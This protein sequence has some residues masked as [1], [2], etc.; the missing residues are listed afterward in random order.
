[1]FQKENTWKKWKGRFRNLVSGLNGCALSLFRDERGR[2]LPA[3]LITLAVGSLLLTPF[4]SFVSTRSLGIR[5]AK[6]T[7]NEQYASDAGIEFGIWA[8]LND[9]TFRAQADA[10]PGTAYAVPFPE[11][12]NGYTPSVDITAIPIGS[13]AWTPPSFPPVSIGQGGDMVFTGGNFIYVLQG[14]NSNGFWRYNIASNAWTSLQNTQEKVQSNGG[15]VY[16]GGDY[17]YAFFDNKSQGKGNQTDFW[18][19]SISN[20]NWRKMAPTPMKIGNDTALASPGGNLIYVFPGKQQKF[21]AYNI[22]GDSW[23]NLSPTPG[24]IGAGT[25]LIP[26]GGGALLAFQGNS[27]NFW[28]YNISTD[29]WGALQST[30][31][32]VKDGGSLAYYSGN[33]VYAF[34]G[35]AMAFWRYNMTLNAWAALTNAPGDVGSGGSLAFTDA[36]GGYALQGS[37]S[38]AFWRFEVTPPQ[39]DIHSQAGSVETTARIEIDVTNRNIL[40]W[41]IE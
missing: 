19:Y 23:S 33:Y 41:D 34:Q 3:A 13:W 28:I 8:L 2:S 24:K 16:P 36:E 30:P 39:Y 5:A 26:Y 25:S 29:N 11:N 21:W 27:T 7:F 14:G 22:S 40:F 31:G 37:G 4:L 15:L 32:M 35:N 10:N 1:M 20:D 12:I 38:N 9:N 6:H 18:R 17:I